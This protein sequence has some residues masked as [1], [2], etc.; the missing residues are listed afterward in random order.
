VRDDLRLDAERPGQVR[1]VAGVACAILAEGEILADGDAGERGEFELEQG[2]E[3]FGAHG[4]EFAGE[5]EGVD[6][7]DAAGG[8]EGLVLG[9]GGEQE[10][11]RA[12]LRSWATWGWNVRQPAAPPRRAASATA[13]W[14]TAWW[15]RWTPSN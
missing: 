14:K 4:G 8:D 6:L 13:A 5:G 9:G 1:E 11:A 12:G 2:E 7:G 3:I 10:G 15:P